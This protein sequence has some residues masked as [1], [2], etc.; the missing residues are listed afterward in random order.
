MQQPQ[1]REP[2]DWR[3]GR[4]LRAWELHQLGWKQKD[5]AVALGV[6]QG[7][8][9]QW[10]TRAR[11]EGPARLRRRPAPGAQARLTLDQRSELKTLLAHGAEAFGFL[12]NV[13]TSKR[14]TAII[15]RFFG[16]TYHRAHVSRLLRQLGLSVQQPMVRATQ[17]DE[18]VIAAWW[19]ERW[20][21]LKKT[22][23][24]TDKP[25]SG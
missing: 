5:I 12:G 4:R 2:T 11:T 8:V 10:L 19:D 15:Q 18:A 22:L 21:E 24:S 14:V 20:P 23:P 13:W 25:S 9:S 7:A 6:T 3:E 16:I 1:H 17:R